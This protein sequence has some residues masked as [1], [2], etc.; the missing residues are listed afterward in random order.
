M[1]EFICHILFLPLFSLS[2]ILIFISP[3]SDFR[4]SAQLQVPWAKCDLLSSTTTSTPPSFTPFSSVLG[5]DPRHRDQIAAK[6][7]LVPLSS[8]YFPSLTHP[9]TAGLPDQSVTQPVT[10]SRHKS[11]NP[12]IRR[13]ARFETLE[14][15]ILIKLVGGGDCSNTF[16]LTSHVDPYRT[17]A[18]SPLYRSIYLVHNHQ[19]GTL[20]CR[21]S[22]RTISSHYHHQL[23]TV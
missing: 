3:L 18:C 10:I 11:P 22:G 14:D 8:Y 1:G 21:R 9:L 2:C 16:F 13:R 15:L 4:S 5:I 12:A 6:S 7:S 20:I 23:S 17:K 19:T